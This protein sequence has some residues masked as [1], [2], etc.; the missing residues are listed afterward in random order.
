MKVMKVI[1]IYITTTKCVYIVLLAKAGTTASG[2]PLKSN[3]SSCLCN[4]GMTMTGH[5]GTMLMQSET[6]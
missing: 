6:R 3:Q 1:R 4:Y 5:D 2:E